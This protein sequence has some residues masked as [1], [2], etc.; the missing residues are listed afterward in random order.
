[1]TFDADYQWFTFNGRG[2]Y[3]IME[4]LDESDAPVFTL[5]GRLDRI[6]QWS[7]TTHQA[8]AFGHSNFAFHVSSF[9]FMINRSY[10]SVLLM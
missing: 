10:N 5:Q 1:M 3:V 8:L 6:S 4:A 7:V 2:D 9:T